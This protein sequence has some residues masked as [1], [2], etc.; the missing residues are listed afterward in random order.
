[1]F[2]IFV[3]IYSHNMISQSQ[4]SQSS[5]LPSGSWWWGCLLLGFNPSL[6]KKNDGFLILVVD[7]LMMCGKVNT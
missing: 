7:N 1:L 6:Y 5:Q 3:D 2:L 4:P